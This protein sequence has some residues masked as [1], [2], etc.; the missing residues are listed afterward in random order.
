MTWCIT[1]A[2]GQL[3]SVLV[4]RLVAEGQDVIALS[5]SR[6]DVIAGLRTHTVDVTDPSATWA[7]LDR[8]R[9]AV[10]VHLAAVTSVADAFDDPARAHRVN[11]EATAELVQQADRLDARFIYTSTDLVFDG[12]SPPYAES[13][14]PNPLSAYGRSKLQAEAGVLDYARGVVVRPALMFGLPAVRRVTTF[15]KQLASLR[16]GVPLNLFDDEYRTPLWLEDAARSIAAV[17]RSDF[18]GLLHLGGP[19]R[20]SRLAMGVAMAEALGLRTDAI[21]ATSSSAMTFPEPRPPDVSLDSSLAGRTF[22]DLP[23]P[24]T[25]GRAT[26]LIA[27]EALAGLP[28]AG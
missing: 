3:G 9:P 8:V 12:T 19:E 14:R 15:A 27:P 23:E 10:V 20:V 25:V 22:S 11:V 4:R 16:D 17:S 2:T 24:L 1:G 6:S 28:R 18:A 7:I 26:A 21:R 5:G 13:A